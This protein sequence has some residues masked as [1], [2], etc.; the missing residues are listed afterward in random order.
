MKRTLASLKG[1]PSQTLFHITCP[2][3]RCLGAVLSETVDFGACAQNCSSDGRV[4]AGQ[5][6]CFGVRFSFQT[7]NMEK[8]LPP[9][10]LAQNP[11]NTAAELKSSTASCWLGAVSGTSRL[12]GC[13]IW[14]CHLKGS[15]LGIYARKRVLRKNQI[16]AAGI[17]P[18][19]V[20]QTW[21]R[22]ACNVCV[23]YTY[24]STYMYIF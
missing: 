9:Q 20:R 14:I 10:G 16:Y 3:Q 18:G 17:K 15:L 12:H 23:Y 2:A 6:A 5:V 21:L 24:I 4:D 8:H 7:R 11:D 19:S 22:N 13:L 1:M